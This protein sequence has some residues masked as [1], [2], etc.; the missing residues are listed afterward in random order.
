MTCETCIYEIRHISAAYITPAKNILEWY[1]PKY[2][3]GELAKTRDAGYH[4]EYTKN[5]TD[6]H[7]IPIRTMIDELGTVICNL[8]RFA[9]AKELYDKR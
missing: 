4:R 2:L 1:R 8:S 7:N 6:G 9:D 5:R 3:S